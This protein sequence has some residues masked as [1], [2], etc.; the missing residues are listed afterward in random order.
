MALNAT[1]CYKNQTGQNPS[2]KNVAILCGTKNFFTDSP[3]DI[4]DC[5]VNIGS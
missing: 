2:L 3:L 1:V 5:T 4:A